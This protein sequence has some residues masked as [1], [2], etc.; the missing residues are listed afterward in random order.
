[1]R[2][3]LIKNVVHILGSG[4]LERSP[5]ELRC[6]VYMHLL[7]DRTSVYRLIRTTSGDEDRTSNP[8]FIT[9]LYAGYLKTPDWTNIFNSPDSLVTFSDKHNKNI[10]S[11]PVHLA[12]NFPLFQENRM[13]IP[14][15]NFSVVKCFQK[16]PDIISLNINICFTFLQFKTYRSVMEGSYVI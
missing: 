11:Y 3:L 1:M 5:A 7:W 15:P 14:F 2:Q 4:T 16:I 8:W 10:T 13:S 6:N 12:T 9:A